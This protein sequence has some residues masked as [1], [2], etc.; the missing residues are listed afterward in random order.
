MCAGEIILLAFPPWAGV[1][2]K[3]IKRS[4]RGT[5][6]SPGGELFQKI[7]DPLPRGETKQLTPVFMG[8]KSF[9]CVTAV[10]VRDF[11]YND[12]HK[13]LPFMHG[14]RSA[15]RGSDGRCLPE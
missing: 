12:V 2:F 11:K 13:Q 9:S 4:L 6:F 14:G 10:V 3:N 15:Y 1:V 8:A 5:L 7:I